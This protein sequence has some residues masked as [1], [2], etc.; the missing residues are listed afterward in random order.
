[1]GLGDNFPMQ[2]LQGA[3]GSKKLFWCCHVAKKRIVLPSAIMWDQR[4]VVCPI[5]T[6]AF[7]VVT[8][9]DC[10]VSGLVALW[11]R[12]VTT[13]YR[14][15]GSKSDQCPPDQTICWSELNQYYAANFW[16][17]QDQNMRFFGLWYL[18]GRSDR[19][20]LFV[21]MGCSSTKMGGNGGYNWI[22]CSL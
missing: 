4:S 9:P 1:M 20:L 6:T 18:C 16:L 7:M 22:P 21:I 15:P 11:I 10:S 17:L 14:H 8:E 19:G 5:G 12:G 3:G 13:F 2:S